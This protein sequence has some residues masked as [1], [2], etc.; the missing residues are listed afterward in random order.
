MATSM[1]MA[2]AMKGR[3]QEACFVL[4]VQKSEGSAICGIECSSAGGI[5]IGRGTSRCRFCTVKLN[6]E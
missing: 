2:M 1:A 5:G 4:H 3:K 6:K